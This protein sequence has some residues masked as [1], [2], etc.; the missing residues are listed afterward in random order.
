MNQ[1]SLRQIAAPCR[2]LAS[3]QA[4]SSPIA[5]VLR[6]EQCRLERQ[7]EE[8]KQGPSLR[9]ADCPG[10]FF[11]SGS[12]QRSVSDRVIDSREEGDTPAHH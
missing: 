9:R 4:M 12:F 8:G 7:S 10:T 2:D 11:G 5:L 6:L 3:R 1:Q